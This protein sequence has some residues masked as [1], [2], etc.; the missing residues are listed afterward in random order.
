MKGTLTEEIRALRRDGSLPIDRGNS[1]PYCLLLREADGSR[2][3]YYFSTPIYNRSSRRLLELR[4]RNTGSS[5]EAE[6]S[7]AMITVSGEGVLLKNDKGS[8]RASWGGAQY[9]LQ[10]RSLVSADAEIYPTLNGVAVKVNNRGNGAFT[11]S[12]QTDRPFLQTRE[13]TKSFSLME[14]GFQPFMSLSTLGTLQPSG[15][16]CAPATVSCRKKD[17]RSYEIRITPC[18]AQYGT[19]LFEINLY[20]AKLFQDTTVESKNMY[21]NN[22]FGSMAFIGESETFGEQWLYTRLDTAKLPE[23]FGRTVRRALL[24]IPGYNDSAAACVAS[25][26][27]RRFC[28]FGSNWDNKI[29]LAAPAARSE[30]VRG[31][32][33][34]NITGLVA[35]KNTGKF[36]TSEGLV[37]RSG[38]KG[39]GFTALA[40][41]DNYFTPQILEINFK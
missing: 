26:A 34:L 28:S 18:S 30:T 19:L 2:S 27:A 7:S 1:N 36:T 6:G 9:S 13:N 4:F 20:E 25:S 35:E 14:E 24:Y 41:G 3:A 38:V 17:D 15:R 37:L 40:T 31:Y 5:F 39:S 10:G 11:M 21:E 23:M 12:L 8:L 29:P 33:R 22:A 16:V 32:Q